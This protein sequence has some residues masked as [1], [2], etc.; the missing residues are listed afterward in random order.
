MKGRWYC[1]KGRVHDVAAETADGSTTFDVEASTTTE[2]VEEVDRAASVASVEEETY[3]EPYSSA[4]SQL[5]QAVDAPHTA[6]IPREV[7]RHP[8]MPS[9]GTMDNQVNGFLQ[10]Q[11]SPYNTDV[12]KEQAPRPEYALAPLD[13]PGAVGS[14]ATIRQLVAV[15]SYRGEKGVKEQLVFDFNITES[16]GAGDGEV[17]GFGKAGRSV[18]PI[19]SCTFSLPERPIDD[20]FV[21]HLVGA[22]SAHIAYHNR[23]VHEE[24]E[25][26]LGIW[27]QGDDKVALNE[28][29]GWTQAVHV[30]AQCEAIPMGKGKR[31]LVVADTE[32]ILLNHTESAE[33]LE[34]EPLRANPFLGEETLLISAFRTHKLLLS[35][36]DHTAKLTLCWWY[37]R[38]YG[39][40]RSAK[41]LTAN[42]L[43]Y[44]R[45]Q[46]AEGL[47][48]ATEILAL[49][50]LTALALFT[51]GKHASF[52]SFVA[53]NQHIANSEVLFGY[54][55]P[56]LL[57][58][59]RSRIDFIEP[60]MKG[61]SGPMYPSTIAVSLKEDSPIKEGK[62][63]VETLSDISRVM[64]ARSMTT[65]PIRP[66]RHFEG[67][68]NLELDTNL[69]IDRRV[70]LGKAGAFESQYLI[71]GTRGKKAKSTR[72]TGEE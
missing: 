44:L 32:K 19:K 27:P 71:D 66:D 15:V 7:Y 14:F 51:S 57:L 63:R 8:E 2:V 69:E 12:P 21:V 47:Y 28:I 34:A 50:H 17:E 64:S 24:N 10:S 13:L 3:A 54:Y 45:T 1:T 46:N 68:E 20:R 41:L 29:C 42:V 72:T 23:G 70:N 6:S 25:T 16:E 52:K 5:P 67:Y 9:F 26:R 37:A 61:F 62:E 59:R 22:E 60:D 33:V 40:N 55:S 35:D 18:V 4:S 11:Y 56:A 49:L 31:Y 53:E 65:I 38:K 30:V 43:A 58:S 36:F 39:R 48:N